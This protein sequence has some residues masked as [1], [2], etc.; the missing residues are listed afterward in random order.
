MISIMF[1]VY[2]ELPCKKNKKTPKEYFL[3]NKKVLE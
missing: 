1:D 3:T 2:V